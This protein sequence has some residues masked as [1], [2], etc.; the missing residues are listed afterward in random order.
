MWATPWPSTT[1]PSHHVF[2][3]ALLSLAPSSLLLSIRFQRLTSQSA[4][5][6]SPNLSEFLRSQ[7]RWNSESKRWSNKPWCWQDGAA[8]R[9]HEAAQGGFL[10][11]PSEHSSSGATAKTGS[12]STVEPECKQARL[13]TEIGQRERLQAGYAPEVQKGKAGRCSRCRREGARERNSAAAWL[14][15]W[16]PFVRLQAFVAFLVAAKLRLPGCYLQTVSVLQSDTLEN[17]SDETA[18]CP[19]ADLG[20]VLAFHRL[21][22]LAL[23]QEKLFSLHL[24]LSPR[25]SISKVNIKTFDISHK[26]FNSESHATV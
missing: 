18:F 21:L 3:D 25:V 15:Y 26:N 12:Y 7:W 11:P 2:L 1:R 23:K 20:A 9:G 6:P 19:Q 17:P 5:S 10:W 24:S 16:T 8:G 22:F 14:A 13:G 4:P